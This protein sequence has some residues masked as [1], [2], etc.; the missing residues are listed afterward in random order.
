MNT[1]ASKQTEVKYVMRGARGMLPYPA[2][3]YNE[4]TTYT[5][6]TNVAP[7]VLFNGTYYVMNK[8]GSWLGT[9]TQ[10]DP[11]K[12]YAAYGQQ[13]TWIPFEEYKAV[14]VELLM[15][16]L[17]L[18]GKSVFWD[19]YTF[20][21]KGVDKQGKPSDQYQK[22][23]S[24]EFIPNILI[25]WVEGTMKL[26]KLVAE[27]ADISGIL[28]AGSGSTIG[29]M[30]SFSTFLQYYEEANGKQKR[31]RFGSQAG[32]SSTGWETNIYLKN[33]ETDSFKSLIY[34]DSADSVDSPGAALQDSRTL[35]YAIEVKSGSIR[36]AR[37]N[38]MDVPG[39]L[40]AGMVLANGVASRWY[41]LNRMDTREGAGTMPFT[42][43]TPASSGWIQ[44]KVNHNLGHNNYVVQVTPY[45]NG[46]NWRKFHA[47]VIDLQSDYF[48]VVL[49]DSGK[50]N[51][52]LRG[53]F[54]FTMIGDN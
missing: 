3:E 32:Y 41:G 23:E 27:G 50:E 39:V 37:G 38:L 18:I 47:H 30:T 42:V 14:Y 12:D 33:D 20:S 25:D 9:S 51:S 17:G 29:G 2:G 46:T 52:T 54:M 11:Q 22:F 1:I 21:Q 35:N 15:A 16:K 4:N 45:S 36:V 49:L 43:D 34:I 53:D 40:V 48:V 19:S 31:A 10:S 5:A 13:A 28:K 24:G 26:L 7:Y 8:I 6:T 44:Y